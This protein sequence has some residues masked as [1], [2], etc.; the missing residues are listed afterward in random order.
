M[1]CML[2]LGNYDEFGV[3]ALENDGPPFEDLLTE[4]R[5]MF[6]VRSRLH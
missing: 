4:Y 6:P 5:T 2:V 3:L 1:F